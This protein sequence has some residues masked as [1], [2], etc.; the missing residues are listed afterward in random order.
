MSACRATRRRPAARRRARTWPRAR[1]IPV[2]DPKRWMSVAGRHPCLFGDEGQGQLARADAFDDATERGED[3]G[4]I[5]GAWTWRHLRSGWESNNNKRTL[6]YKQER[7][8]ATL[9]GRIAVVPGR[10]VAPAAASP[11]PSVKPV[12]RCIAPAVDA[13]TAL[14]LQ[15]PGNDRRDRRD[16]Q[17]RRRLGHPG[18][19]DHT[20]ETE[21]A[22]SSPGSPLPTAASTSSSI[23]SPA[24]TPRSNGT[25]RCGRPTSIVRSRMRGSASGRT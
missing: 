1:S 8:M 16:G 5:D 23:P 13:G 6:V 4:V 21:V 25:S 2:F 7:R 17:R 10:P 9:R 15:A 24:K 3:V 22:S 18:R 11:V 20:V 14:P 19:V 12:Q